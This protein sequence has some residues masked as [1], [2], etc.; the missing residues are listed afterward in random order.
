MR[1][2]INNNFEQNGHSNM[3]TLRAVCL[4]TLIFGLGILSPVT[5][6]ETN[7]QAASTETSSDADAADP[8][9]DAP[10][11]AGEKIVSTH[12][13]WQIRCRE[14]PD[15]FLYQLVKDSRDVPIAEVNVISLS[16]ADGAVAG[17]TI[18][19][20]LR[21]LLTG[22]LTLQIDNGRLQKYPYLFCAQ[23]G[24]A[25]RFGYDAEG[26]AQLKRGN[27]GRMTIISVDRPDTPI[28]LDI[29]LSGFTAA[30]DELVDITAQ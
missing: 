15:C 20:P 2:E 9:Q 6:Q 26:L 4:S 14:V 23:A 1:K 16:R 24:C 5:A 7:G 28:V 8:S 18:V 30:M 22:G 10:L 25:A 21:T 13:D 3:S 29:S 12:K 27:L 11:P 17:V 19:T